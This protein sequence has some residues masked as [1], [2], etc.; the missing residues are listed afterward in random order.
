MYLQVLYAQPMQSHFT[1]DYDAA[2]AANAT[3]ATTS[4]VTNFHLYQVPGA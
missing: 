2:A 3:T 4:P 1:S